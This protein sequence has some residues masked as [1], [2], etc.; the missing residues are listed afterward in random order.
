MDDKKFIIRFDDLCSTA[1]W[2]M[3][4]RI[5]DLLDEY[6]I[7]PILAVIPDNQDTKMMCCEEKTDFWNCV[8]EYQSKNWM[9]ALHG[10]NHKYT[11]H[12]S[13]IMGI[14]A[15]SEFAGYPYDVQKEKIFKGL[16]IFKRESVKAE[17]FIAPSHSFDNVTLRVLKDCGITLIS[18]G[19]VC[20]PYSYKGIS[21]LPCQLWEHFNAPKPG[22]FTVCFHP[23]FW[24]EQDFLKFK[25]N[26]ENYHKDIIDPH[27]VETYEK[28]SFCM[29]LESLYKSFMFKAKRFVKKI[30][31][32]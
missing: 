24:K 19:H 31:F 22:V 26:I 14:S 3:W 27:D 6:N 17:A 9:I 5:F 4:Q 15:N 23:N 12:K 28:I 13:G 29:L 21:W 16:E 18:D 32:K 1:N 25:A 11:N 7:K 10:Y 30:I 2:E 20:K 8:R